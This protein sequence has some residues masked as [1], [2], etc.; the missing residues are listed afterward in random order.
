V[1]TPATNANECKEAAESTIERLKREEAAMGPEL[2]A[3]RAKWGPSATRDPQ[4]GDVVAERCR[5]LAAQA[6]DKLRAFCESAAEDDYAVLPRKCYSPDVC[7]HTAVGKKYCR[8]PYYY[9]S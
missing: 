4:Y 2:M 6:E 9:R 8:F 3:L 5:Q 7:S 1:A